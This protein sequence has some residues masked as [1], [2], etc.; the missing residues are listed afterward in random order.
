MNIAKLPRGSKYPEE[1]NLVIEMPK[2][3]HNKYEYDEELDIIKIDRVFYTAM[4]LPHDYGFIP[5]TRS[6]DGDHLDGIVLLDEP[7]Y[8][9]IM[10]NC[11]PIGVAYMIDSGEKDEK[12]IAV[13][14]DDPRYNHITELDQLGEH[15]VKELEHYFTRY[16]DLQGKKV[17]ITKWGG[18]DEA[19]KVMTDSIED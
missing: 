9:G 14:A 16:K 15:F 8:P 1:F 18:R 19:L 11:R 6:E 3:S 12:I 17:E 7:S 10:V 13:C 5:A 4:A 2:N